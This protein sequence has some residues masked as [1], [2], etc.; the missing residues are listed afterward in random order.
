[1]NGQA[2]NGAKLINQAKCWDSASE[3]LREYIN[4]V[5]SNT[6]SNNTIQ[7]YDDSIC[8]IPF[9]LLRRK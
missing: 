3:I 6:P 7:E 1:M 2:I 9:R 5:G 4:M 8:L